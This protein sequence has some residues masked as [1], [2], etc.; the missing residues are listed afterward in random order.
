LYGVAIGGLFAAESKF[1]RVRD[2]SKVAVVGL[3]DLLRDEYADQRLVDVQ[4]QTDHLATLGVVEIPRSV[5][6][7][8]LRAA[9]QVPLPPA[10]R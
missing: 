9:L 1:H 5:Y 10:F 2:A 7:T 3:V 6:L 8:R 4:W